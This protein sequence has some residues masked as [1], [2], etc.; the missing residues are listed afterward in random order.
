MAKGIPQTDFPSYPS[1]DPP[2]VWLRFR[3]NL[4]LWVIFVGMGAVGYRYVSQELKH[5]VSPLIALLT[6]FN[7]LLTGAFVVLMPT[8][9][10]SRAWKRW[11]YGL[12]PFASGLFT[13]G[14]VIRSVVNLVRYPTPELARQFGF[15]AVAFFVL[16]FVWIFVAPGRGSSEARAKWQKLPL[17]VA[18]A[19]GMLQ[20]FLS[21]QF[22]RDL[23]NPSSIDQLRSA[24]RILLYIG[25][26]LYLF[27]ITKISLLS[28][29]S[30]ATPARPEAD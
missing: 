12:I 21:V 26:T 17:V 18:L 4:A 8:T 6:T 1:T 13:E 11:L 22:F 5:D 9:L 28:A 20:T 15:R 10:E 25:L 7:V 23:L 27:L 16:I 3:R 19:V 24:V 2:R 30:I 14:K 29:T